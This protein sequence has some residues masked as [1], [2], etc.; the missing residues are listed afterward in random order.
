MHPRKFGKKENAMEKK[1]VEKT[2][3]ISC[4]SSYYDSNL[5]FFENYE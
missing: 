2:D 3:K 4:N 1:S 5:N